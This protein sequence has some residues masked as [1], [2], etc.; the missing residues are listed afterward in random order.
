MFLKDYK[1]HA[2]KTFYSTP[3]NPACQTRS[4]PRDKLSTVYK[5]PGQKKKEKKRKFYRPTRKNSY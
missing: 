4:Q 2:K 3:L 5:T 1:K